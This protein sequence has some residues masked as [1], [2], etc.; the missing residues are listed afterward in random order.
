MVLVN[1]ISRPLTVPVK[2]PEP[3]RPSDHM[4]WPAIASL[5][6]S[7]T[8]VRVSRPAA[9]SVVLRPTPSYE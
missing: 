3:L 6:L 8:F 2:G 5:L 4:T 1:E 7:V 9:L